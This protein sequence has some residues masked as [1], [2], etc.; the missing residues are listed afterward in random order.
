M[1]W[2]LLHHLAELVNSNTSGICLSFYTTSTPGVV[3]GIKYPISETYSLSIVDVRVAYIRMIDFL[4]DRG[5]IVTAN[6]N[7][8]FCSYLGGHLTLIPDEPLY[9][10]WSV[11]LWHNNAAEL[12]GLVSDIKL[13]LFSL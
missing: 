12:W 1:A 11:Y 3:R 8:V 4:S 13:S 9:K 5:H 6:Y 2:L 7:T 10:Y